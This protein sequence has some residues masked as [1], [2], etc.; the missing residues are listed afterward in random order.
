VAANGGAVNDR[1]NVYFSEFDAS[2]IRRID[3]ATGRITTVAR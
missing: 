1:G 3:A 2:R